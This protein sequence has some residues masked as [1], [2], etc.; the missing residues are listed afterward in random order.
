MKL[1]FYLQRRFA[2]IGHTMA[3][4][5]QNAYKNVEFCGFVELRTGYDYLLRQTEV[6]Y[7]KLVLEEEVNS[8]Y[9]NEPLDLVFLKQLEQEYGVPYL[10]QHI[11]LD[12]VIRYNQLVRDYP[13]DTPKYTHEEMLRILQVTAKEVLSF[14][15]TERP[16]GIVF[17]V[18]GGLASYLLNTIAKAK[19]I[20]IHI[21]NL[22]RVKNR[23][24]ISEDFRTLTSID[25]LYEKIKKGEL[26]FPKERSLAEAFLDEF[27]RHP[28]PYTS[29]VS[30]KNRP[31][32]R[33][34]QLK[35]LLPWN[36]LKSLRWIVKMTHDYFTGNYQNDYTTIKP[37]YFLLDKVQQKLRM[38]V[39]YGDIYNDIDLN[40]NFAFFP[41]QVEPEI[42]TSLYAPYF[43]DQ[44]W[45]AKQF[46][47]S[48]PIDFKLYI[49]EHPAM[50][51]KR[52]LRFYREL[53]KI[54]NVR[55]VKP[56]VMSFDLT[57]KAALVTVITSTVGWEALL[58]QKPVIIFGDVFFNKLPGVRKCEVVSCLP[59]LVSEQLTK[60]AHNDEALLQY[61][62]AI[63]KDSV[64]VNLATIWDV[65]GGMNLNDPARA[66]ELALL[67][68]LLAEKAG[69]EK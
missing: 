14:L 57:T 69:L 12:R 18:V 47:R 37:W 8:R 2:Y 43:M 9:K 63:Y 10:W 59:Q 32:T 6:S 28:A 39:G 40:H 51:G 11:E 3:K 53:K 68:H 55:L 62:T 60:P 19:G 46:A 29:T 48:L 13:Y 35:F 42:S 25:A 20:K 64:D 16:D 58:L 1:C 5:L 31:V 27:R 65:E 38:L 61:L 7:T 21:I 44:I 33:N 22:T 24:S 26:S 30:P 66:Q 56:N 15:E 41:L 4:Q 36:A 23:Y 49:K 67:T 54:P 17:S 45:V 52:P 50:Y 34:R